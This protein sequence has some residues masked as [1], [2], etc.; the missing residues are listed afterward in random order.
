MN[1]RLSCDI[2]STGK[3]TVG[4]KVEVDGTET[5]EQVQSAKALALNLYEQME[6][7][8]LTK[9]AKLKQMLH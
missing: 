7:E 1:V 2:T 6:S 3:P 5:T 8:M 4:L 9:Y